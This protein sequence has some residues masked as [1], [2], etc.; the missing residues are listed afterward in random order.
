MLCATLSYQRLTVLFVS[1]SQ[2][3]DGGWIVRLELQIKFEEVAR[4]ALVGM[5]FPAPR[6]SELGVLFLLP[7]AINFSSSSSSSPTH[8]RV[9]LLDRHLMTKAR[10][11]TSGAGQSMGARRRA[12]GVKAIC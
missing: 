1:L 12:L 5:P 8:G 9:R 4:V 10:N 2:R 6:D 3:P 11:I 7:L